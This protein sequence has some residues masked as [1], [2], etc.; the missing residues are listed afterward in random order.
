MKTYVITTGAI[1]ALLVVV[2][3]GRMFVETH[4]ATDPAYIA[5][6]AAVALLGL[7][8]GVLVWRGRS[9]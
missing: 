1:F 8:A 2:H 5:I 9:T 4:L 7:W 3:I 6:T